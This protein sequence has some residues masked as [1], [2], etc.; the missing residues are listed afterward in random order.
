MT[1]LAF[2]KSEKNSGALLSRRKFF[3]F[4]L[5]AAAAAVAAPVAVK[6]VL[7][8][9]TASDMPPMDVYKM[10]AIAMHEGSCKYGRFN[11]KTARQ[12]GKSWA[13]ATGYGKHDP[14]R[15][16]LMAYAAAAMMS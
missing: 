11:Y 9:E 16:Q 5:S 14:T 3:G 10:M 15:H 4:S 12:V 1:L 8:M 6:H 2:E 13:L 7:D